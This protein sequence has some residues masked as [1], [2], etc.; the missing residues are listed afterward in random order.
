VSLGALASPGGPG[1]GRPRRARTQASLGL[2]RAELRA[3]LAM[4]RSGR[5]SA[6][7]E[8][9]R[10]LGRARITTRA[11]GGLEGFYPITA[12]RRTS[13]PRALAVRFEANGPGGSVRLA[14]ALWRF[15]PGLTGSRASLEFTRRLAHHD[16]VA[17]GFEEQHGA[18]RDPA[19]HPDRFR[20]GVWWEWRGGSDGLGLVLREEWW[21]EGAWVRGTVRSVSAAGVEIMGPARSMLRISHCAYRVRRGESLY[22]PEAES[23]RLVLRALSGVGERTRIEAQLPLAGG[24]GRATAAWSAVSAPP[25]VQWTL[26]WSRRASIRRSK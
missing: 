5:W 22:L 6:E 24:V 16:R 25:L 23:D 21:G 13:P 14:G 7:A 9:G 11:R 4:D 19:T 10:T 12:T 8:L 1:P 18:R 2:E 26:D 3:E 17:A 20:Q 15:R